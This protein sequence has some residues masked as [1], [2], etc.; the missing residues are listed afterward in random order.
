MSSCML[1][2]MA[3]VLGHSRCSTNVRYAFF[4]PPSFVSSSTCVYPLPV[5]KKQTNKNK[6]LTSK[7]EYIS[8]KGSFADGL[9]QIIYKRVFVVHYNCLLSFKLTKH[10]YIHHL[11]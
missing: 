10:V 11:I 4:F 9:K 7:D 8:F 1:K 6:N 2:L 5:L 3:Q